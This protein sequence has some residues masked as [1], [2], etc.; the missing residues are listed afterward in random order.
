MQ[1]YDVTRMCFTNHA[2]NNGL[3]TR[4]FPIQGVC[5]PLAQPDNSDYWLPEA[6]ACQSPRWADVVISVLFPL[7]RLKCY[8]LSKFLCEFL[9]R[10]RLL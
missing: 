10:V 1:Q 2:I 7:N 5:I 9:L 4:V 3:Y 8:E 6:L